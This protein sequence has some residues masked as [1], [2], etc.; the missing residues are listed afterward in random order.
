M[1]FRVRLTDD[2]GGQYNETTRTLDLP[3]TDQAAGWRQLAPIFVWYA[4]LTQHE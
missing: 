2:S 1:R 4:V 3:R